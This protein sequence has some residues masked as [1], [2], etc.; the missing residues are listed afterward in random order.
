MFLYFTKIQNFHH[1]LCDITPFKR[2]KNS[3]ITLFHSIQGRTLGW[4]TR[5]RPA[6][7]LG[8]ARKEVWYVGSRKR[9]HNR[10]D[11]SVA[12]IRLSSIL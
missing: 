4:L 11:P 10:I 6:M 1:L 12:E 3:V 9:V 2:S 8:S 5:R 7:R